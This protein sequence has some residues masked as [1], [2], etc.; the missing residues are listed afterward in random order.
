MSPLGNARVLVVVYGVLALAAV[1]RS[2]YQLATRFSEAPFA[3]GL[4]ALAALVY[5][6]ATIALA[7]GNRPIAL[8]AMAFELVGVLTVGTLSTANSELF[9]RDT[10]WSHF[11][12]GYLWV[13]LAL[14]II[15]MWWLVKGRRP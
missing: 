14:P 7:R 10:V 5:V 15:G 3:Y 1:G 11:G 12:A 2:G 8:W 13:P 6:V 9:P 4:S